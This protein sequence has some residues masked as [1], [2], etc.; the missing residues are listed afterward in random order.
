[1]HNE[2][3]DFIPEFC[4]C[5]DIGPGGPWV[6]MKAAEIK[7]EKSPRENHCAGAI[8]AASCTYIQS[9]GESRLYSK[10][11][12]DLRESLRRRGR[13]QN[14]QR[15]VGKRVKGR[16]FQRIA[17]EENANIGG[18]GVPDLQPDDLGRCAANQ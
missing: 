1:M 13:L 3:K 11:D 4:K 8:R 7:T 17:Q 10:R 14:Q 16:D 12:G 18:G 5:K 6:I 2:E 15:L 9:L